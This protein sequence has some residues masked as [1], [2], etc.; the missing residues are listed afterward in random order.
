MTRRF[1]GNSGG[2]GEAEYWDDFQRRITLNEQRDAID[3]WLRGQNLFASAFGEKVRHSSG[4]VDP[5]AFAVRFQ[6]LLLAG[7]ASKPALDLVLSSYY[8]E[9]WA[10]ERSMLEG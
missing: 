4:S 1:G 8:T 3:V 6:L 5:R 2:Y 9:A 10:L 7:R